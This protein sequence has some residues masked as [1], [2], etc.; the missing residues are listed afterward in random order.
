MFLEAISMR[1]RRFLSRFH[2]ARM[3]LRETGAFREIGASAIHSVAG[4]EVHF[5]VNAGSKTYPLPWAMPQAARA[6]PGFRRERPAAR[7]S[8]SLSRELV[9]RAKHV[10]YGRGAAGVRERTY[11]SK[12]GVLR[13]GRLMTWGLQ[14]LG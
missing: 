5:V 6:A 9:A 1:N 14:A 4:Q 13:Q 11:A 10:G 8:T 7:P 3:P 2:R 12:V